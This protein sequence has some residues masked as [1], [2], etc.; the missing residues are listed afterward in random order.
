MRFSFVRRRVLPLLLLG[1]LTLSAPLAS[2]ADMPSWAMNPPKETGLVYGVGVSQLTENR[3]ES[4]DNVRA[5][6]RSEIA[7]SLK[8][9]LNS[10]LTVRTESANGKSSS[11]LLNHID[12]RVPE[13][14]LSDVEIREIKFDDANATIYAL[15]VLDKEAASVR[16]NQ[17]LATQREKLL[18][19]PE[20]NTADVVSKL[21]LSRT[22][23]ENYLA[24]QA[25]QDQQLQLQG[26]SSPVNTQLKQRYVAAVSFVESLSVYIP[27]QEAMSGSARNTLIAMLKKAGFATNDSASDADFTLV[28]SVEDLSQ[29]NGKAWYCRSSF[30]LRFEANGKAVASGDGDAKAV[31]GNEELACIKAQK[32]AMHQSLNQA[33]SMFWEKLDSLF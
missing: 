10:K 18:G 12:V 6:A 24:Y 1:G 28:S 30:G 29:E 27:K 26:A 7:K 17:E 16:L 23:I 11:E 21:R 20:A 14:A 19:L 25:L 4:I 31:S 8:F 3:A 2:Y 22:F 33:T 5:S 15:A 32:K 13:T 9:S